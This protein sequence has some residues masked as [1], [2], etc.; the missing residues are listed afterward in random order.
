M[1]RRI[2][3]AAGLGALLAAPTWSQPTGADA[4]VDW[5]RLQLLDGSVWEPA[6]WRGQPALVVLW[7]TYCPFCKRH[8]AHVDKLMAQSAFQGLR[9]LGIAVDADERLVR[10]YMSGNGYRFPVAMDGGRLRGLLTSRRV[11]PMT[12]AIDRQGRLQQAIPG[13]MFEE[14]LVDLA[15]GLLK[16]SG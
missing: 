13:E 8:N 2:C 15:T 5:P 14:D 3:L 12:C 4:S 9:M 6:S 16:R 10:Q 11:I 1:K 7:A